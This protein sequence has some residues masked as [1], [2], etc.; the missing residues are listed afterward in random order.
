[1]SVKIRVIQLEPKI[2]CLVFQG[3]LMSSENSNNIPFMAGI[4]AIVSSLNSV[5]VSLYQEHLFKVC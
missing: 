3:D 4:L 1:M 2:L 5:G